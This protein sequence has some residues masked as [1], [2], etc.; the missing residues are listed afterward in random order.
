MKE[1][2][3]GSDLRSI[4]KAN[5]VVKI[6]KTQ[7][8][9]DELFA[10]LDEGDRL[11]T[12]RSIDAIEK[13][14]RRYP[15]FLNTHQRELLTFSQTATNSEFKWHLALLLARIDLNPQ[16]LKT[17]FSRLTKWALNKSESKIVRVNALQA[18]FDLSEN[19]P[20]YK[21]DFLKI[22]NAVKSEKVPSLNARIKKLTSKTGEK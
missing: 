4:S 21:S 5:E 2:L 8:Q 6:V 15:C 7:Q 19:N 12:M 3:L 20:K 22:V 17:T 16:E 11:L 13:I 1:K 10:F 9:F 18:L 14:T